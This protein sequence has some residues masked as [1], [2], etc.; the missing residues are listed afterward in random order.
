MEEHPTISQINLKEEYVDFKPN[1]NLN[2]KL[3]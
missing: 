3:N 2:K 1:P